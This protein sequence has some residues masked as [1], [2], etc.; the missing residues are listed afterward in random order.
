[1]NGVV[2]PLLRISCR[3]RNR[4]K[5]A[6]NYRATTVQTVQEEINEVYIGGEGGACILA[7]YRHSFLVG[8][9]SL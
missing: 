8:N 5:I 7:I 1:M 9:G 4:P 3:Q 6:I 2:A